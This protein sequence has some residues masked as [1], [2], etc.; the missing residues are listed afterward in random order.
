MISIFG[1]AGPCADLKKD[2]FE[3]GHEK[4]VRVHCTIF[5]RDRVDSDKSRKY[6]FK[7]EHGVCPDSRVLKNIPDWWF[8]ANFKSVDYSRVV[9][10]KLS[11][12]CQASSYMN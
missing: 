8:Y 11:K 12:M 4:R 10:C 2:H 9:Q 6:E 1:D 7:H 3:H 5:N